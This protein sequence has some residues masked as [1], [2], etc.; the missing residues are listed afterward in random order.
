MSVSWKSSR[1]Y[2]SLGLKS[3]C[4]V[5]NFGNPFWSNPSKS[6]EN[7]V[8]L[9]NPITF[10]APFPTTKSKTLA[11]CFKAVISCVNLEKFIPVFQ[12]KLSVEY[13]DL[14]T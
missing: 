6:K 3:G 14:W 10:P 5:K 13:V 4:V 12:L 7:K 8:P 1:L 2:G 11:S 9:G